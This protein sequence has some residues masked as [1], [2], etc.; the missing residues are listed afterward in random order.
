ME[1]VLA[2]IIPDSIADLFIYIIFI[3]TVITLALVPE[4]NM[5]PTMLLTAVLFFC[6][7]D[8]V[9]QANPDSI[10]IE[11]FDNTGFATMLIHVGMFVFPLMGGALIRGRARNAKRGL[12]V[13]I[14]AGV[15]GGL[16]AAGSFVV[17]NLFYDKVF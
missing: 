10:P 8:L 16:Y 11:G 3:M 17:P 6:V 5:I 15:L 14:M 12:P 1:E 4:K 2:I 13:A 9:R 7:V